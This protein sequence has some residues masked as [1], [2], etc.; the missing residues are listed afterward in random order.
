MHILLL[1]STLVAKST[2]I[3][4]ILLSGLENISF[5]IY[6]TAVMIRHIDWSSTQGRRN[7]FY[8]RWVIHFLFNWLQYI[9]DKLITDFG[10]V[11]PR[12]KSTNEHL[13]LLKVS[14]IISSCSFSSS[15]SLSSFSFLLCCNLLSVI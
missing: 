7:L 8:V 15:L 6:R 12:V 2:N 4:R 10:S 5:S 13:S 1:I 9:T 11:V 14:T 3:E